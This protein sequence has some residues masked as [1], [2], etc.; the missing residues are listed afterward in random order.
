MTTTTKDD[1]A[2]RSF[3][4]SEVLAAVSA[5]SRICL[6]RLAN[7]RAPPLPE[8][9]V[10]VY[11]ALRRRLTTYI[12]SV[13]SIRRRCSLLYLR[14]RRMGSYTLYSR[15]ERRRFGK[16]AGSVN[17]SEILMM[18]DHSAGIHLKR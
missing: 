3:I 5:E 2:E 9:V 17:Y 18:V 4:P 10:I 13:L 12:V 16:L 8:Y 15:R 6:E 1:N 14:S 7:H 11:M